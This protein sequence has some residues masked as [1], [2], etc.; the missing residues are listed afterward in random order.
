MEIGVLLRNYRRKNNVYQNVMAKELGVSPCQ[1][2]K[3]EKGRHEP[4]GDLTLKILKKLVPVLESELLYLEA[5]EEQFGD[6]RMN[7]QFSG[8]EQGKRRRLRGNA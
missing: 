6:G 4:S 3:I 7:S 2:S 1:L 5:M 8:F